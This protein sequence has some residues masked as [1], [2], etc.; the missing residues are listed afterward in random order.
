MNQ[1][2]ILQQLIRKFLKQQDD[3]LQGNNSSGTTTLGED[4]FNQMGKETLKSYGI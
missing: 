4:S 3:C 1:V 2:S